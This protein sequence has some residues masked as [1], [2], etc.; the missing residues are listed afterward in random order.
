MFCTKCGNPIDPNARF[1]NNCGEK[2]EKTESNTVVSNNNVN[3]NRKDKK[4]KT[5]LIIFVSVAGLIIILGMVFLGIFIYK[6]INNAKINKE[7]AKEVQDVTTELLNN[8]HDEINKDTDINNNTTKELNKI[9]NSEFGYLKVEDNWYKYNDVDNPSVL[10]YA[11]DGNWIISMYARPSS[12]ID[13]KTYAD[14]CY[15]RMK[16]DGAVGVTGATVKVGI[17]TAYQ[18]YGYYTSLNK[19][20]VTW[21]FEPGDKKTHYIGIEGPDRYSDNFKIPDTFTLY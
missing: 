17:Y 18:V 15:T 5:G 4:L 16:Q 10:E 19:W 8:V 12:T 6:K 7:I 1:C 9:G 2:I 20:L 11:L 14:S 21:C 13:A 3:N